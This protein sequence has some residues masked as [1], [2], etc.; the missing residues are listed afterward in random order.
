MKNCGRLW[1]NCSL[2][3]ARLVRRKRWATLF[4]MSTTAIPRFISFEGIDGAG[5]STHIPRLAEHLRAA[6]HDVLL[7]REPGG[8]PLAEKLRALLL[9]DAMDALTEALLIFAARRDHL[10]TVIEP[11][12]AAGK[13][14]LCDRFTDASFAYQ[15]GGRGFDLGVLQTLENWVQSSAQSAGQLRQP[16]LTFWFDLPPAVAAQRLASARQADRFEAQSHEFF[17]KVA[18]GYAAR[19]VQAGQRFVRL[20][21]QQAPEAVWQSVLAA[22]GARTQGVAA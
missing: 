4:A 18:A 12:L 5:K 17:E 6:G 3:F 2:A 22:W 20:D 7:T 21:A 1:Q 15:G 11:A 10:Q 13:I 16:D 8:T 14:V 19:A 9:H